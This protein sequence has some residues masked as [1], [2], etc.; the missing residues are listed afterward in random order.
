MEMPLVCLENEIMRK[1]IL[2]C[3][4]RNISQL[5]V[6]SVKVLAIVKIN[7]LNNKKTLCK[8]KGKVMVVT[9]T[10]GESNSSGQSYFFGNEDDGNY[11]IF[12]YTFKS[13]LDK[14]S[15]KIEKCMSQ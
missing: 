4:E 15:E 11:M 2:G 3:L 1:P 14:D 13:D 5:D 7:V 6:V 8:D 12:A 10:D 9:L